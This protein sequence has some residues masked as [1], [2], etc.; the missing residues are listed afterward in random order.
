MNRAARR[1]EAP[2]E[3]NGRDTV[4]RWREAQGA[5]LDGEAERARQKLWSAGRKS[6]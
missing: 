4:R 5:D 2:R 3:S 1:A 6:P